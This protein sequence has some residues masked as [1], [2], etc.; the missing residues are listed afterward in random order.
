MH[1]SEGVLST[2]TLAAGWAGAGAMLLYSLRKIGHYDVPKVALFSALFFIASFI[3]I[4]I[5]PASL[6]LL[7]NGIVGIFLGSGAIVAI[8]IALLFQALLFGY[9]G[10]GVLGINT[11]IIALPAL[12][13]AL[14][15]RFG[16]PKAAVYFLAGALPVALSALL[17]FGVLVLEREAYLGA[18]ALFLL[19]NIPLV[20]IEGLVALFLIRFIMRVDPALLQRQR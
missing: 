4:P 11:L 3:H 7:L 20:V 2:P 13:G 14:M 8:F 9:G 18:G 19:S 6:H 1:I 5:G 16:L 15:M 10:M 17:M 12:A